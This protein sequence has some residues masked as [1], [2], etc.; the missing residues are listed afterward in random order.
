VPDAVTRPSLLRDHP[1]DP[2]RFACHKC[3]RAGQ[4]RRTTLI[5]RYGPD[6]DMTN[7][8]LKVAAD[9]PRRIENRMLDLCGI[10]YPGLLEA[11]WR[12]DFGCPAAKILNPGN[13]PPDAPADRPLRTRARPLRPSS[14]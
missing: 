8:R 3:S 5:E 11:Y 2:V 7:L 6:E 4:H 9:C 1:Y 10:H 12:G 14:A 13:S